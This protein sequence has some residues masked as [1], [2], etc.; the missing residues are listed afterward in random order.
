MKNVEAVDLSALEAFPIAEAAGRS[1]ARAMLEVALLG[2]VDSLLLVVGLGA[3][4]ASRWALSSIF[5]PLQSS[6]GAFSLYLLCIACWM[7][8][9]G[10]E[11]A[12]ST[13]LHRADQADRL[14]KALTAGLA[15]SILVSF[16][17]HQS[18]TLSRGVLL[19]WYLAN[20]LLF[21][22]IRP[23]LGHWLTRASRDSLVLV[24]TDSPEAVA[25]LCCAL[26]RLG[27]AFRVVPA[28]ADPVAE[29]R[30]HPRPAAVCF[31]TTEVE[32]TLPRWEH[33]FG[34]VGVFPMTSGPSVM[35]SRPLNLYG[36]QIFTLAH[37]L[38]HPGSRMLKR[39]VDIVGSL[40]LLTVLSPLIGCLAVAVKLSSPGP[41]MYRQQR[42]GRGGRPFD[43]WKFRSMVQDADCQLR[44][45]LAADPALRQEY[46]SNFK[47]KLDPRITPIGRLLRRYSLDELP[48]LWNV[49][50]GD[51][52][53]VGPRPIVNSEI[54]LYG[55]AYPIVSGVRPGMTGLWQTSGR[56]DVSYQS[57]L[58]FDVSYVRD[59]TIWRDLAILVRTIAAML[60]PDAY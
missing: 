27:F 60:A 19:F 20:L 38:D 3:A 47:L 18:S 43:L 9:L 46:E 25:P 42:L 34:H 15:V 7:V 45:L 26:Q 44:R 24:V 2:T 33:V 55:E 13:S 32:A 5:Y 31:G 57:R 48:Q 14:I 40:V 35:G 53:L 22:L 6:K 12:Y 17:S 49:L 58:Q 8:M 39:L 59:W 28:D 56:S 37:P 1:S 16:S 50:Q 54:P 10:Y 52:S 4:V 30:R 29:A 23:R 36:V 11:H 21:L 51:M 41:V